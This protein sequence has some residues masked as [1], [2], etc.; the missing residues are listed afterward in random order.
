MSYGT[1]TVENATSTE[2]ILFAGTAVDVL[3]PSAVTDGAFALLRI[4][5][6][7]G[8][9]T[10]PHRHQF[11]DETVYV[12]SGTMQV[13]TSDGARELRPGQALVLPRGQPHQLGNAG[14]EEANLLVLCTPGGFDDFVRAAGRPASAGGTPSMTETDVARLIQAAPRYG[15]ELLPPDAAAPATAG[16]RSGHG[17]PDV[18]DVLGLGIEVLAEPGRDADDVCLLRGHF[19][20]GAEVPWHSHADREAIHV[21]EGALDIAMG[22]AGVASWATV[23]TGGTAYVPA[24]RPHAIRNRGNTP[25][26]ALL[27]ATRRI[28]D[29]FREVGLAPGV[30]PPGSPSPERLG[31]FITAAQARGFVL[32]EIRE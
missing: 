18:L 7:P 11:E 12:L 27:V 15:I 1:M 8:C 32:G 30:L 22:T 24:H 2:T 16:T 17:V 28:A 3:V 23:S 26:T 21:L 5:N 10:P 14:T 20:P 31:A 25:A 9:W 4:A 29:L 13:R 19:P 6:P